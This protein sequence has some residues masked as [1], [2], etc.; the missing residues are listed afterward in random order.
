MSSP[1]RKPREA[2]NRI[3]AASG[4]A[5]RI[6]AQGGVT[7]LLKRRRQAAGETEQAPDAAG[8]TLH[9]P[10]MQRTAQSRLARSVSDGSGTA[11]PTQ[12]HQPR[13][14]GSRDDAHSLT[15]CRSRSQNGTDTVCAP[16]PLKAMLLAPAQILWRRVSGLIPG[17]LGLHDDDSDSSAADEAPADSPPLPLMPGAFAASSSQSAD[18]AGAD[19]LTAPPMNPTSLGAGT[20]SAIPACLTNDLAG[21]SGMQLYLSESHD[22][23]GVDSCTASPITVGY[24]ET[25][26][27]ENIPV[28]DG[29]DRNSAMDIDYH[30][31]VGGPAITPL[32]LARPLAAGEVAAVA[33]GESDLDMSQI[34]S[35]ADSEAEAHEDPYAMDDEDEDE[36]NPYLFMANM[37]PIPKEHTLRPYALPRKTRSSPP[38]TLVLDL[39]E[40][41]VHCALTKVDNADLVF[42]VE[43]N[44]VKYSVYCR[45]RPGYR[46]FL[47]KASKLF[48]VVVFTASQQVYADRLL[49]LIDPHRQ[50]IRHRLFRDSCVYVNTNYVKDLGIL[51]RDESKLLLVDNCPQ[52][53][54]Y[55]Q[56]NGIPI[57][58]W[59]ED[60]SDCELMRLMEFLETL[61][62]VDDVRPRVEARFRTR[63]KIVE[64]DRR[65]K[66]RLGLPYGLPP[67][68]LRSG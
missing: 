58:S 27:K 30:P 26:S 33:G 47:E 31:R 44:G 23:A 45:L 57:E 48:E 46:E 4:A 64:A 15:N 42:P 2:L 11:S 52:A 49:D 14:Q 61:V 51:G 25:P 43:Y 68:V 66:N 53:F 41:L 28:Y 65:Y 12:E 3:G 1:K 29:A 50:Y 18:W 40:T 6:T 24:P 56:S 22:F 20:S 32:M 16:S 39:D 55:Q 7:P 62:G 59:Y 34:S 8:D 63:E 19:T 17:S 10:Q 67:F 9:S 35:L 38:I 5:A 36:F 54:A 21:S 13:E 60:K 37:P